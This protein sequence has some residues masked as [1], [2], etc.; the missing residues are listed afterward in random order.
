MRADATYACE[1]FEQAEETEVTPPQEE[2]KPPEAKP[3]EPG[4]MKELYTFVPADKVSEPFKELAKTW[5][6]WESLTHS[7]PIVDNEVHFNYDGDYGSE[8]VLVESGRATIIPDDGSP[9]V[10]IGPGDAMH[11]HYGFRCVWKI[12]EPMV[13]AYGYYDAEGEGIAEHE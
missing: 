7:P 9:A 8:R 13:Q 1:T 12:H 4:S 2:V 5:P 11:L 3:I 6:K 10:T